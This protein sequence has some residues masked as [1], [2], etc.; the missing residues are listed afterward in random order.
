M[1]EIKDDV[2][3]QLTVSTVKTDR[4]LNIALDAGALNQ[5]IDANKYQMPS[6][7]KT[8]RYGSQKIR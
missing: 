7:E 4:S 8:F 3:I 2:F 1:N 6:L 5:A